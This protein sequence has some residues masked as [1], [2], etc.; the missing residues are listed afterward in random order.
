[1]LRK[2]L[3][4]RIRKPHMTHDE[5]VLY[6]QVA[7]CTL[8]GPFCAC[9]VCVYRHHAAVVLVRFFFFGVFEYGVY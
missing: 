5:Q 8:F 2:Y 3:A 1:M 7:L 9:V 6:P 4:L